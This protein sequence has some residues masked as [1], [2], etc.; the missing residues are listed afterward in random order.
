MIAS[1][2]S[3][4]KRIAAFEHITVPVDGS[5]T[6]E[7][8]VK[9]ALEMAGS[10][11][12][13]TFCSVVD[14]G[15]T[16][17]IGDNGVDPQPLIDEMKDGAHH[18]CAAAER[19]AA[20]AAV[21]ADSVVLEGNPEQS[22]LHLIR[23][24]GTDAIVIGT[25]GRTGLARAAQGS[26]AEALLR[27]SGVPVIAVHENDVP[28][29][30]PI[31]VALDDSPAAAVAL[32]TAI[33]LARAGGGELLLVHVFGNADVKHAGGTGIDH[34]SREQ[35]AR[36]VAAAML[37]DAEARVNGAGVH[38]HAVM[39]E[40]PAAAALLEVLE[41]R[42]CAAVVVGTHGRSDFSRL[43]LGS[44]STALVERARVPVIVAKAMA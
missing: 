6:S 26:L 5:S 1:S 27:S 18:F 35:K 34:E 20:A 10:N 14:L 40:G 19:Q 30:G 38:C 9:F 23:E 12:T 37:E 11:T 22:I 33:R 16:Y 13:I 28:R 41:A 39:V 36:L 17:A 3:A 8:G 21:R 24:N 29:T 43:F 4:G 32:G 2:K 15:A 25:H 7:R 44:V 42:E 31:A